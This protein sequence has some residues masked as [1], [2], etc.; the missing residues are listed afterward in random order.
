MCDEYNQFSR[1]YRRAQEGF[2]HALS[3]HP[4]DRIFLNPQFNLQL[5]RGR[6]RNRE[7]LPTT[8]EVAMIIPS[9]YTHFDSREQRLF[10][11]EQARVQLTQKWTAVKER[12]ADHSRRAAGRGEPMVGENRVAAVFKGLRP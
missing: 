9:E 2:D 6:D 12:G 7:N 8:P 1:I 10:K 4:E 11:W 3:L 5:E